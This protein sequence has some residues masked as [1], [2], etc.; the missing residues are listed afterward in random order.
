MSYNPSGKIKR[1]QGGQL[2]SPGCCFSCGN[3]AQPVYADIGQTE[4]D[5]GVY[6][7]EICVISAMT[8]FETLMLPANEKVLRDE[9]DALSRQIRSKDKR[10][11]ELEKLNESYRSVF[12]A[13]GINA[14][15]SVGTPGSANPPPDRDVQPKFSEVRGIAADNVGTGGRAKPGINANDPKGVDGAEE[16]INEILASTAVG[17]D[18][19]VQNGDEPP[20]NLSK[21]FD[22][23]GRSSRTGHGRPSNSSL[24]AI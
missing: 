7:C 16:D 13:T 18:R 6:L 24:D 9:I 12:S 5:G 1:I 17:S 14:G 10:I 2:L 19:P 11:S 15:V 20:G 21:P 8:V 22:S 3:A 23:Q 4:W